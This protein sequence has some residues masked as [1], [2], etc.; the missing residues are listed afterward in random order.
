[1]WRNPQ[2]PADFVTFTEDI[3]N[4]KL[5]FLCRATCGVKNYLLRSS[6]KKW[7]ISSPWMTDLRY[8]ELCTYS[9]VFKKSLKTNRLVFQYTFCNPDDKSNIL[10][11]G[12]QN[13]FKQLWWFQR[14][15]NFLQIYW[16]KSVISRIAFF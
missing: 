5:Q 7:I 10:W 1:M 16:P 6:L 11:A 15:Q 3:L 12:L 4:R 14:A 8:L 2:F 9:V 13:N